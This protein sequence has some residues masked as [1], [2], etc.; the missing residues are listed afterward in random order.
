MNLHAFWLVVIFFQKK[1][2]SFRKPLKGID[3][4]AKYS[5]KGYNRGLCPKGVTRKRGKRK[6]QAYSSDCLITRLSLIFMPS[7]SSKL[8]WILFTRSN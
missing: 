8:L 6:S 2:Q 4:E 3:P 7:R 1:Y 5:E